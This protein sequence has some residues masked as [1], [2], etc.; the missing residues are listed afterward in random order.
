MSRVDEYKSIKN[1]EVEALERVLKAK[2]KFET[3]LHSLRAGLVTH[4]TNSVIK[5]IDRKTV[6]EM[7]RL[8]TI[9]KE[10]RLKNAKA[11]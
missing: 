10:L 5:I 2:L 1:I 4:R 11:S 9:G 8:G 3:Q 6:Y 7:D